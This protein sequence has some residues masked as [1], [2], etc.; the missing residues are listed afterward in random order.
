MATIETPASQFPA[1]GRP[2]QAGREA[3][4]NTVRRNG[5]WAGYRYLLWVRILELKREPEVVFW[6]FIFPLLLAAG[7][8][9]AFRNKPADIPSVVVID[10]AGAQKTLAMLQD[11]D[12]STAGKNT[13]RAAVLDREAALTAFHFGKYDLAIE[14]NSDGSYTYY[15][16]PAR[17]ESVLSRAEID[18]Q[19]QS[20]AGRKDVLSTSAQ[21]SSEPGSRYIDFLIPGLLGMNLMN[22]GM[23]GVGFALVEMRQRKLLKRFVATPMR[24]SDFLLALT[25]S[26]LVLMVIEIGLLLGFGVLVFHMRIRGSILSVIL[27]GSIGAIAFGGVGLLTACRAQKIESVSGLINLVMMPMWIFS[28]VF[29]SYHKFP[30]IA[31]PFIKALPLTALNDA[32]RAV[33]LEGA[34]FGSQSGRL[35][36]LVI[37]GGVSFVLALRWFRWT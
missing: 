26:R 9:I 33:I 35:L 21:S 15:Y 1:D 13:I 17:P 4:R 27:L 37:W 8:G 10:N 3:R 28:G 20:A 32:L 23:W 7:L 36:V 16:D 29:F 18:A 31:Q 12:K 2:P 25:S 30:A 34:S 6:V 14:S 19:L 22:S 5:R 24:R 11:S